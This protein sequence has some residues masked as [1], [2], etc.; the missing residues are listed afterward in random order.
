[1]PGREGRVEEKKT[2]RK[3]ERERVKER[4]KV[5][6]RKRGKESETGQCA[7]PIRNVHGIRVAAATT[8][9]MQ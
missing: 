1:M 9:D 4:R 8:A 3:R 5:R 7:L 2:G 6:Y